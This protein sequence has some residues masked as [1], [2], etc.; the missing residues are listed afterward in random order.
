MD[1]VRKALPGAEIRLVRSGQH[2]PHSEEGAWEEFNKMV[3]EF[4]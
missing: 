2:S 3:T 1:A 4:V